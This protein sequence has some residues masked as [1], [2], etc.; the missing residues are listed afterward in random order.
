MALFSKGI[1][2]TETNCIYSNNERRHLQKC[3][4]KG[5][6]LGSYFYGYILTQA[7][8]PRLATNIGYKRVWTIAMTLA[9]L[10]TL[11]TPTLA[12]TSYEWL[13]AGRIVLGKVNIDLI[14][15]TVM[16]ICGEPCEIQ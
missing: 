2:L 1:M 9:A 12:F 11:A 15:I 7:V 8:G 6:I 3:C 13:F 10:L 5:D 16:E 4:Q 14:V